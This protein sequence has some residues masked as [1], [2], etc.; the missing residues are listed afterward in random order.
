MKKSDAKKIIKEIIKTH[1][2]ENQPYY[3][4]NKPIDLNSKFA[5]DAIEF[6]TIEIENSDESDEIINKLKNT[7]SKLKTGK[8]KSEKELDDE[9]TSYYE[10]FQGFDYE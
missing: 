2:N 3:P 6:L 8:F 7:L 1:L 5:K 9:V 10:G 4:S